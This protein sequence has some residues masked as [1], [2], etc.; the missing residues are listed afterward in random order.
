MTHLPPSPG[1]R[2]TGLAVAFA[3]AIG[4]IEIAQADILIAAVGPMSVT[5]MTGQYAMFGEELRRGTEL[6]VRHVNA[7]GGVGSQNLKLLVVDD[8]CDP[9]LAVEVANE[10]VQQKVGLIVGHVCSGASLAASRVYH[11]KG[12]LMITPASVNTRL[13]EQGFANVFRTCGR[14]DTQARFA[15][16]YVIDNRLAERIAIVQDGSAFG[17]GIADAFRQHLNERGRW[18]AMYEA[19]RQGERDFGALIDRMLGAGI[20]LVY[21][22][23]YHTEAGLFARQARAEGLTA[24]LM[25]NS[26]MVNHEFWDLAGP[27]GEGTLMTFAPDPRKLPSAAEVVRQFEA[28]GYSPEGYTL[29]AYTAVQVFAEAARRAGSTTLEALEKTLH[30]G[31]YETVLGPIDFDAKGDVRNFRYQMYRWHDGRYEAIC[32]GTKDGG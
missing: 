14:D 23:G 16:D 15:A 30:E 10:L 26:A 8:A 9:E 24:T 12:I 4:S 5:P 11:D 13:T 25:V 28:E 17:K 32:C 3:L 22:G 7:A 29:H 1:R 27:G 21:F 6:A 31:T 19:I 18:E 2:L 20:D